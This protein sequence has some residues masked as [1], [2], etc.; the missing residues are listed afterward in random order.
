MH[1][2]AIL[3]CYEKR[4]GIELGLPPRFRIFSSMREQ[5]YLHSPFTASP[6]V[7]CIYFKI[8]KFMITHIT[9]TFKNVIKKRCV[10][11]LLETLSLPRRAAQGVCC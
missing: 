1:K 3:F 8:T 5:S 9:G 6:S 4:R 7:H 10:D 2:V 11:V